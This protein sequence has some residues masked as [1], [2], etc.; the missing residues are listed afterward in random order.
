MQRQTA[1]PPNLIPRQIFRLYGTLNSV[2]YEDSHLVALF[3]NS[4]L[5]LDQ[6]AFVLSNR[7]C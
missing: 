4:T 3:T 2:Y 1:K 7:N 5:Y 6:K